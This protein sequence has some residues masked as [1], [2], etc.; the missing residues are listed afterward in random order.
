MFV[1]VFL[2]LTIVPVVELTIILEVHRSIAN[3]WGTGAGLLVTFGSIFLSGLIGATLIHHQG[4]AALRTI[5]DTM[6]RGVFPAD[7]LI[8]GTMVLVGGALLLTPGFLTD[9][10][11]LT[12]LIPWTRR[13]WRRAVWL[14]LR[15]EVDRRTASLRK[16]SARWVA[17]GSAPPEENSVIDVTPKE[18]KRE[19][20]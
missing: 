20:P 6:A 2:L 8:D 1:R 18:P 3:T 12:M 7:P 19:H 11:G 5:R 10:V 17:E 14:W 16:Q 9:I 4:L 15:K 13:L